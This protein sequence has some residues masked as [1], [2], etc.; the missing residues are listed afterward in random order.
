[1]CLHILAPSWLPLTNMYFSRKEA[2]ASQPAQPCLDLQQCV[3]D[4]MVVRV[5]E[6][7][8]AACSCAV[9]SKVWLCLPASR[10]LY[11]CRIVDGG[12]VDVRFIDFDWARQAGVVRYPS[13]INHRDVPWPDGVKDGE[14]A[15]QIHD[16]CLLKRHLPK[17][18]TAALHK[19]PAMQRP[20]HSLWRP[21]TLRCPHVHVCRAL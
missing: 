2:T 17:V 5:H 10:L 3:D 6:T 4:T 15:L 8:S 7:F 1:M 14:P 20:R 9:A 19:R 18:S 12:G 21:G 13:F 16:T 11:T